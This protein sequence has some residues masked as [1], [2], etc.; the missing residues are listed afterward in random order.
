[1]KNAIPESPEDLEY[2]GLSY[3]IMI[4]ISDMMTHKKSKNVEILMSCLK[5][6]FSSGLSKTNIKISPIHINTIFVKN[7]FQL[8]FTKFERKILDSVIEF[9]VSTKQIARSEFVVFNCKK[10]H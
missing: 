5:T 4:L 8:K 3:K 6:F 10:Y 1:M 7:R 2:C 9:S